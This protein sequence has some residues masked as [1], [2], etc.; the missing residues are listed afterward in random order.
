MVIPTYFP[1]YWR[2]P[3]SMYMKWRCHHICICHETG[4]FC[5]AKRRAPLLPW[6]GY[7]W[8]PR[9]R[10]S[11]GKKRGVADSK[12][13]MRPSKLKKLCLGSFRE[14]FPPKTHRENPLKID[15]WKMNMSFWNGPF[16]EGHGNFPGGDCG[17]SRANTCSKAQRCQR[18]VFRMYIFWR[19]L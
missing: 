13:P 5:F 16:F 17:N 11:G 14:V 8:L 19:K 9:R 4:E 10:L 2:G 1:G 15:G 7:A 3:Q 12:S 6:L 18:V